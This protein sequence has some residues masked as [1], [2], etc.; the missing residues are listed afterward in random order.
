[1]SAMP[2]LSRADRNLAETISALAHCN[3]FLPERIALERTALGS[4]FVA[5]KA[6]WNRHA[7]SAGEHPNVQRLLERA[8]RLVIGLRAK[9]GAGERATPDELA[10]YED[11]VLFVLYHRHRN[12]FER[13]RFTRER[14]RCY[15]EF[16]RTADTFFAE[17]PLAQTCD[18]PHAFACCYQVRRAFHHIFSN[19]VG[20]SNAVARLRASVWQSIFTHDLRRYRRVLFKHMGDL[21][22]L[23]TGPS[24][25]GKE[26]VARAIAYARYV[27]FEEAQQR[28]DVPDTELFFALNVSALAST[29]VES[30]LFGHRRGSF[31]GAVQDRPGWLELCPV[32]G[33]VFLD[34]VGDIEASVQVKLL[35]VLQTRLFQR[36]GESNSRRFNGKIIAATNR[37]LGQEIAAGRFR[38]DFYYRLCSDVVCT[39]SL[40][41]QLGESSDELR[42]LVLFIVKRF[43]GH[44]EAE[45]VS[46]EVV[47]RIDQHLGAQYP[48]SGNFR[49]LEQCVR[50]VLVRKE[51]RGVHIPPTSAHDELAAGVRS[52]SLTAEE[53]LRRYTCL[54][55]AQTDNIEE[56][57]RRMD[58]DRRTVKARVD[59][60]L[61]KEFRT[62]AER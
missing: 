51:Y 47:A 61:V 14:V 4:E 50:N 1:M 60:E 8:E 21:T 5:E 36:L 58:L 25:T 42:R 13:D 39:A 38:A 37:D 24:G 44:E 3:P 10:R 34:E 28:F 48:W 22:T 54:V 43:L 23:I 12:D 16:R 53:L 29:L 26:L 2:L 41:E 31:T 52:G 7:E 6:D 45:Q 46:D 56:T 35:R 62:M 20:S 11:L 18:L 55:H 30:E 32:S 15:A 59:R 49:E 40:R 27:P 33:S 57:A 17:T 19:I 9:L